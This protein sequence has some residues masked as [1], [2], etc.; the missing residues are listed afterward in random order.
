MAKLSKSTIPSK[1]KNF[2]INTRIV[3]TSVL[4]IVVP[5]L[6]LST[7]AAVFVNTTKNKFDI[8]LVSSQGYGALS[9]IQW[10]QTLD[11][12]TDVLVDENTSDSEKT[13]K[14]KSSVSDIEEYG[15][16][17]YIEKQGQEFY[18]T[19]PSRN[20]FKEAQSINSIKTDENS[21]YFAEDG[22]VI[23]NR[24]ESQSGEYLICIVQKDYEVPDLNSSNENIVGN[25][26]LNA[27]LILGICILTFIIS[28]IV[29]SLMTSKTIIGPIEKITKGANEIAKGN[30]G[31]EIDYRSTNE[32]GQLAVSF[33]DMRLRVKQSIER[34][35]KADQQQKEMI[36]GIAHDLRTP[37]TSIKGYIEGLRDGIADTPEKQK[38][39]LNTIY[40]SADSMEK[41]LSDL[42]TISKL[43]LGTITL[44][45]E[46]VSLSDFKEY[47]KEIGN[48]LKEDNFDYEIQDKTKSDVKLRI[49][50]DRF[51]RV[52]DNIISNSIKYRREGVRGKITLFISEYEHSVLFE[53]ADNGMGVEQES[54]TRIFDTLYR[55]D[56]ARTNVSDG[57][58]L[59]L[60]VCKQIV[61]LHG[62]MIWAQNNSQNGLSIFISLPK[63]ENNEEGE[64]K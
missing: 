6:I 39:Y 14:L 58:G 56:K 41:M 38:R 26:T 15:A 23:V 59:G 48:L 9:Q 13:E 42:L 7:L 45:C 11:I 4:A 57:S 5:I 34:Q 33:N 37:L 1:T 28:I 43:E 35:N 12:I 10:S 8:S 18:A 27:G 40:D 29:L 47:A 53:I 44:N 36:A 55:A 25:L 17:V 32:L 60:A 61:E 50:T 52:I 2:K 20:I 3:I 51:S 24:A 22:V 46:E 19:D 16:L 49:D 64:T 31:Y 21:Y 63:I 54:L 30:L 62:G